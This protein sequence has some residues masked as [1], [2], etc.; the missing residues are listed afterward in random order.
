MIV[1]II[2]CKSDSPDAIT[3][4]FWKYFGQFVNRR[5]FQNEFVPFL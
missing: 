1:T 4:V 2:L 3:I 5:S